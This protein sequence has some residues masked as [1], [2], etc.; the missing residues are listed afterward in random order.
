MILGHG[1]MMIITTADIVSEVRLSLFLPASRS[2]DRRSH[3]S[4]NQLSNL[5]LKITPTVVIES[6]VRLSLLLPDN[7]SGT[8]SRDS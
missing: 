3:D 6:E 4:C 5:N 7:C 1:K 8:R 2:E